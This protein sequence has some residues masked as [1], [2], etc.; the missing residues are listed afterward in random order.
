MLTND[1]EVFGLAKLVDVS[2]WKFSDR[3]LMDVSPDY[4]AFSEIVKLFR[5]NILYVVFE[6]F[7]TQRAV[8]IRPRSVGMM[9]AQSAH[10]AH[11]ECP[12]DYRPLG[13]L[14]EGLKAASYKRV[15][16]RLLSLHGNL[17]T[18]SEVTWMSSS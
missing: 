13:R 14:V 8:D 17:E 5:K 10:T 7:I 16:Q 12:C 11:N 3:L 18:G 2:Q 1:A 6:N 15:A 9:N 4:T